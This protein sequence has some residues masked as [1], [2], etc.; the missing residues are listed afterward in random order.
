MPTDSN[1]VMDKEFSFKISSHKLYMLMVV[2]IALMIT[3]YWSELRKN[4]VSPGIVSA[5]L[6]QIIRVGQGK[7]KTNPDIE[8]FTKRM[9]YVLTSYAKK[10]NVIILSKQVVIKGADDVTSELSKQ[11][12]T[13]K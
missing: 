8:R 4:F 2:F 6:V 12:F 7:Y 13:L 1:R 11:I 10:K 9:N 5:D 3:I